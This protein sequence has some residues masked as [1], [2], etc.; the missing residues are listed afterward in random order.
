MPGD[1]QETHMSLFPSPSRCS[2]KSSSACAAAPS[3]RLVLRKRLAVERLTVQGGRPG[4]MRMG[5]PPGMHAATGLVAVLAAEAFGGELR[6][7]CGRFGAS[8]LVLAVRDP[9]PFC[10]LLLSAFFGDYR[11][12]RGLGPAK[13]TRLGAQRRL[14]GRTQ[15]ECLDAWCVI[16][17]VSVHVCALHS[18]ASGGSMILVDAES[19]SSLLVLF[20]G[21]ST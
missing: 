16:R 1:W 14:L 8:F 19:T 4:P 9:I 2:A 15:Q 17:S 7:V 3:S 20:G 5:G 12:A 13:R 10:F 18:A 11:R 6:A 21:M